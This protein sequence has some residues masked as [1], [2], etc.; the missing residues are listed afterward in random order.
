MA[1]KD[2]VVFLGA[3]FWVG[4]L[5][6]N[7]NCK[8]LVPANP[9]SAAGLAIPYQLSA[10]N[11]SLG[12]CN[13]NNPAQ[14]AFVQGVIFNVATG[15]FSVYNPLVIDAGT[16]PLFT[17]TAPTLP[18]NSVVGL[19]FGF[20]GNNLLLTDLSAGQTLR[21]A[22]CVNGLPNDLF[23]E[24]AYCNAVAFFAAVAASNLVVVPPLGFGLDGNLCP[25]VRDFSVV[26]M[27]QSDNVLTA[28]LE[29]NGQT[30]QYSAANLANLQNQG[31]T[32]NILLNPS[33]NR[34]IDALVDVSLGCK[35]WKVP[36]LA[37][38]NNLVS[39]L[40]LN[41]I[42]AAKWQQY[43]I[44][45]VPEGDPMVLSNGNINDAKVNLYRAGVNQPP[46]VVGQENTTFYCKQLLSISPYRLVQNKPL[47]VGV[48]SPMPGVASNLYAFLA[49]RLSGSIGPAPG[50]NCI[51]LLN[52]GTN[53]INLV[54]NNNIVTDATVN[55]AALTALGLVPPTFAHT[56]AI[57]T[58]IPTNALTQAATGEGASLM[59][60]MLLLA[61][62]ILVALF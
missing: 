4:C 34:L 32:P 53:P 62:A 43:P 58:A 27:D 61:F 8:L 37:D 30:A 9:L 26:D 59:V 56:V 54:T 3:L 17:P 49:N 52:L 41:E 45:L 21:G 33:D 29:N 2:L 38:N 14:T 25:T 12:P 55:L 47:T 46:I 48:G 18:A 57:P 11:V 31:I 6:Q 10:I 35:P 7:P 24:F 20:N 15:A 44:A 16:V 51:Q 13:Q 28:Y 60:Q 1:V 22:N 19:W 39:A 5:A 42:F 36:D 23:G 50:L 40:P